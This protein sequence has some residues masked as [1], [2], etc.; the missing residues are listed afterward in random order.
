MAFWK[1][2][3][4]QP[5]AQHND[6]ETPGYT[7]PGCVIIEIGRKELFEEGFEFCGPPLTAAFE[8]A[9]IPISLDHE[10]DPPGY[11]QLDEDDLVRWLWL[12]DE[13]IIEHYEAD[14]ELRLQDG[15]TNGLR[16]LDWDLITALRQRYHHPTDPEQNWHLGAIDEGY[17]LILCRPNQL[18]EIEQHPNYPGFGTADLTGATEVR[19]GTDL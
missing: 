11:L 4:E 7:V 3:R 15:S 12:D 9:G 17:L 6:G 14:V 8:A 5:A 10:S 1:R 16:A 13:C 2:K 19:R 18:Q